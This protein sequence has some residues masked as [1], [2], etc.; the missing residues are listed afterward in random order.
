MHA[1]NCN[2]KNN[3]LMDISTQNTPMKDSLTPQQERLDILKQLMPEVFDEGKIDWEKLK[4]TLGESVDF[5][6]DR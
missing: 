4:A 3:T 1:E 5:S 6:N 2:P